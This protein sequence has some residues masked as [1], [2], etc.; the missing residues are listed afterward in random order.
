MTERIPTPLAA[1]RLVYKAE[2]LHRKREGSWDDT[3]MV[4]VTSPEGAAL[5]ASQRASSPEKVAD[6]QP[7]IEVGRLNNE[8][9]AHEP[10]SLPTPLT[11]T[12]ENG[13]TKAE[14]LPPAKA[15]RKAEG[16]KTETTLLEAMGSKR[17]RSGGRQLKKQRLPAEISELGP[18]R[19]PEC[20]R[21][22]LDSLAEDAVLIHATK[23]AGIHRRTPEYWLKGS[24]A[25]ND[26]YEVE[27]RGVTMKFHEHYKSAM[28]EGR[29]CEGTAVRMA[30]GYDEILTYQGRVSYKIDLVR[31]SLGHRGPDAY[32]RDENGDPVPET[33]RK[34]DPKMIRW[35]LTRYDKRA[36]TNLT[37]KTGVLVIGGPSKSKV[38]VAQDIAVGRLENKTVGHGPTSLPAPPTTTTDE[39]G[40]KADLLPPA[41]A[42]SETE[43]AKT[44]LGS[45]RGR[46]GGR[47]LKKQ[48]LP[49]EISELG[50]KRTPERMR[51]FL[52]SLSEDA[53]LT[54]AT[55]K[56]GI[57]RRTPE[58]WLKGSAAGQPGYDLEWRGET[59]KFHE[60]YISALE[61]GIAHLEE[62][63][64]RLAMGYD[65]IL[66]YQGR[67]SYKIDPDLLSLG[68]EG[69][70][71]YLRDEHGNPIPETV[72]KSDPKM[73][74]WVLDRYHPDYRQD[75]KMAVT[76]KSGVLVIG[77]SK[78]EKREKE[79]SGEQQTQDVE[80]YVD[81]GS[82][83]EK[84][85]RR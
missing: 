35:V 52:D 5:L 22:V 69:P 48:R 1:K 83:G 16:P 78:T 77:P 32:Q 75:R 10:T 65:E 41:K 43:G 4:S 14:L 54:H 57:H 66:T 82:E 25:G 12:V 51:I 73:L 79:F 71:A 61:N 21:I 45:K 64:F 30:T 76:Q 15:P 20:M 8:T 34:F 39:S 37:H 9:A 40:T 46:S 23:K 84:G 59:M 6:A 60:H 26:G 17:S 58:N 19:T 29:D 33:V 47:Q 85:D 38:T 13:T 63:A 74:R 68:Q 42:P 62:I 28:D 18:K 44:E 70:D 36:T 31:W 27:W 3:T 67:V 55:K 56:A 81:D 72:R 7:T 24:A 11:T 53:V 80:F 50:R 49:A 2:E